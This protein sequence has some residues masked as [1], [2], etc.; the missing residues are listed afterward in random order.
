[1][2]GRQ[3]GYSLYELLLTTAIMVVVLT[4]GIPTFSSLL[5][6]ERQRVELNALFHAVHVA[7]KESIMRRRVV[8]LCPSVDG[9]Q[10][11]PGDDWSKGWILF[12]N[13]DRD[14]P[15]RV[16]DDEPILRVHE[17]AES[18]QI[19]ANRRGFTLRAV[20]LR[21]TNG[22]LVVCDV[23]ARVPPRALVISYTGRPRVALK[24]PRGAPYSCAD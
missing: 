21:A 4:A 20:F 13:T 1:M 3:T 15:P 10:C 2:H 7:R 18:M 12:E 9:R 23:A 14:W 5:A 24:K 22:T 16:D 6:R 11:N 19:R 8:S 17:V